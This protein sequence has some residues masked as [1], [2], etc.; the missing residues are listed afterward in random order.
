MHSHP[1]TRTKQIYSRI[2][3]KNKFRKFTTLPLFCQMLEFGT[4]VLVQEIAIFK[5][6][7]ISGTFT[8]NKILHDSPT[9]YKNQKNEP[10][11]KKQME[12]RRLK[13]GMQVSELCLLA[14]NS[15]PRNAEG[16][17]SQGPSLKHLTLLAKNKA[18][19]EALHGNSRF[20]TNHEH[21]VWG[22]KQITESLVVVLFC[23]IL[24]KKN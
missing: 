13:E 21:L 2:Q 12:L 11:V 9:Q 15:K 20:S 3:Q 1:N 17:L 16:F 18:I 5:P 24:E 6:N 14:H 19:P 23:T 22:W 7:F 10:Q 8:S 4:K